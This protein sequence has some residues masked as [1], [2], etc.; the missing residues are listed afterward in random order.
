MSPEDD[1]L[2]VVKA[3]VSL[4]RSWQSPLATQVGKPQSNLR[5]GQVHLLLHLAEMGPTTMGELAGR[6][7]VSCS[8]ATEVVDRLV[9][10]GWVERVADARDRRRVLVQLAPDAHDIVQRAVEHKREEVLSV[11]RQLDQR[12]RSGLVRGLHLL[13]KALS[14]GTGFWLTDAVPLAQELPVVLLAL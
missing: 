13:G 3:L 2:A 7:R 8:T 6:L 14:A 11:L 5:L 4:R 1:A 9:S 10:Q 12:E